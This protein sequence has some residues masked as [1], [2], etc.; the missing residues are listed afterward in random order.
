MQIIIII[1]A[2]YFFKLRKT[3]PIV[4]NTRADEQFPHYTIFP[5]GKKKKSP[6]KQT[7]FLQETF[8]FQAILIHFLNPGEVS[9]YWQMPKLKILSSVAIQNAFA[10]KAASRKRIKI[11]PVMP[12]QN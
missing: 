9:H 5:R 6:N 1:K 4:S 7:N 11:T 2:I 8:S 10:S 3:S 12:K